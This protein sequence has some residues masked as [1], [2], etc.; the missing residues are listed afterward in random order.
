MSFGLEQ[1]CYEVPAR[2]ALPRRSGKGV[3]AYL[4]EIANDI[5]FEGC[6]RNPERDS[7]SSEELT[8]LPHDRLQNG[9]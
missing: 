9:K 6:V 2:F 3:L 7:D 1:V 4:Y 5:S 8:H